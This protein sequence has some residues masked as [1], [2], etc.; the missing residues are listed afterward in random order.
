V[1]SRSTSVT[2]IRQSQ[3]TA[4]MN[5]PMADPSTRRV[6]LSKA[7]ELV[8]I[9]AECSGDFI[10]S[11][12]K[13]DVFPLV[14]KLLGNFAE[15]AMALDSRDDFPLYCNHLDGS[16][17]HSGNSAQNTS[18]NSCAF[19]RQAS[20][21]EL[22]TSVLF[23]FAG[24]FQETACGR[25][26]AD[27]IPTLGTLVLPFLGDQDTGTWKACMAALRQMIQ[28]DSDALWRPL[29][30]L[31]GRPF[32]PRKPWEP[33]TESTTLEEVADDTSPIS[34]RAMELVEFIDNQPE[35]PL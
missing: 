33:S 9:M 16:D 19:P 11:R 23:C 22:I 21:T 32:P 15:D 29:V 35:Q 13:N 17:R 1:T 6:F 7:F 28:I 14:A 8:T 24:V 12:F 31:S 26:I 3:T 18:I 20:E 27:L 25:S 30:H 10:A 5:S 34:I 2:I 4:P